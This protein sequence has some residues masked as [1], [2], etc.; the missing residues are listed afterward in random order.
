[1]AETENPSAPIRVEGVL[2]SRNIGLVFLPPPI[3][4]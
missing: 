2:L 3:A 4:T 1:M